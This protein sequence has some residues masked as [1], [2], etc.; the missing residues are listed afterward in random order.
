VTGGIRA[1]QT[2]LAPLGVLSAGTAALGVP[3]LARLAA[4]DDRRARRWANSISLA[5]GAVSLAY[6]GILLAGG[7]R[8]LGFVFGAAFRQYEP[9]ILP[10]VIGQVA[11]GSSFGV[12][13]YVT[14]TALARARVK[15]R[16][17]MAVVTLPLLAALT[18]RL[19]LDGAAWGMAVG[20]V[21]LAL[22]LRVVWR[23]PR[24]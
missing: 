9:A 11:I 2:L 22:G 15:A 18:A 7:A 21:L 8:G 16:L 3:E 10:L 14:A 4:T 13:Q 1:V 24:G 5:I 19:G 12:D 17:T 6:G 23:L 20:Y